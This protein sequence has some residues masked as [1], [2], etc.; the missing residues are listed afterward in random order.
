MR[1]DGA[2]AGDEVVQI[3]FGGRTPGRAASRRSR[4]SS[5]STLRRAKS[6]RSASTLNLGPCLADIA[7]VMRIRHG[8][9]HIWVGGGQPDTV[10][11]GADL[12]FQ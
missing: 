10:A 6:A 9:Y 8:E 12:A 4:A 7:G 1:N 5:G 11:A 3:Y 2:A